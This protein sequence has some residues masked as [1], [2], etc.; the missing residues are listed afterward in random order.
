KIGS[1]GK[2]QH[3]GLGEKLLKKAEEI[4]KKE[5]KKKIAIISGVGVREYYRKFGY[6]LEG[7][8][9]CKD[10]SNS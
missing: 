9:M 8:Y 10:F 1:K 2:V 6:H 5:N 7:A 3:T 4:S